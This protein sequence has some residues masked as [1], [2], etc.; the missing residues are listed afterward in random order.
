MF[1]VFLVDII[2]VAWDVVRENELVFVV[3]DVHVG[4]P[5]LIVKLLYARLDCAKVDLATSMTVLVR[6]ACAVPVFGTI[7]TACIAEQTPLVAVGD[8]VKEQA[9]VLL[10]KLVSYAGT[11]FW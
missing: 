3:F 9:I 2:L 6:L 5:P 1:V 7:T 10:P 4:Q 8:P 11:R